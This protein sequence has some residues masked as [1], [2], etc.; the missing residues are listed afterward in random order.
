MDWNENTAPFLTDYMGRMYQAGYDQSYRRRVLERALAV[1]VS[2]EEIDK[3]GL[4]LVIPIRKIP[5]CLS[6]IIVD[7]QDNQDYQPIINR[8]S[9]NVHQKHILMIQKQ[10]G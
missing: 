1:E 5:H 10:I 8:P 9:T 3:K 2:Q 4:A 6:M 7:Y